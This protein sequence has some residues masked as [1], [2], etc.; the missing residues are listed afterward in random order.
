GCGTVVGT[1]SKAG[2]VDWATVTS[3]QAGGGM[4][5]LVKAAKAEGTLTVIALPPN[6]ANYG[7][8][9]AAFTKKYGIK[10]VSE[11]PEGSSAQEVSSLKQLQGTTREPDV[12]DVAPQ[13]AIQAQ[14]Q[15]LL[16]PYQV[17]SWSQIPSAEKA[18]NGAWYYD[19]GGYISIGY[20]ASLIHQPPQTF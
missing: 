6:W 14:Q 15:H 20:N 5:A 16:A 19:Y 18:S 2:H 9:E 10:I 17:A 8:I 11:N 12:V 7:A 3:A 4:A 13:F 1:A